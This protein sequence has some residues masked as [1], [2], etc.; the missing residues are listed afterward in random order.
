M[1]SKSFKGPKRT[2]TVGKDKRPDGRG[3]RTYVSSYKREGNS[4]KK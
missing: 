3:S 2:Y 4:K 1:A